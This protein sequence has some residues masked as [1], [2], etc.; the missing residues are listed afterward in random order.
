MV[1]SYLN[2]LWGLWFGHDGSRS[3]YTHLHACRTRRRHRPLRGGSL[4]LFTEL[5]TA[6]FSESQLTREGCSPEV[7][8]KNIRYD[9]IR[10]S[11]VIMAI[12]RL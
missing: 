4:P 3:L 2:K 8:K 1:Y 12:T 9:T 11:A 7:A 6:F 10:P 5:P